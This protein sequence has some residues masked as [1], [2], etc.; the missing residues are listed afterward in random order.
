M[1][2]AM[3]NVTVRLHEDTIDDLDDEADGR[4]ISR[5]EYIREILDDR[6]EVEQL[7]EEVST[8]QNRLESRE[9]RVQTLEEQ[10]ARRSQLEEKVDTLAKQQDEADAPFFI[11]WY[12]WW[13]RQ[14]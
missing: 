2:D 10:L 8:L 7:T 13:Q 6:H 12:R 1:A 14:Q 3:R 5:S 4:D 9:E 11:K